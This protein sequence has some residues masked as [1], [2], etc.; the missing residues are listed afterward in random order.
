MTTMLALALFTGVASPATP[1][2]NEGALPHAQPQQVAARLEAVESAGFDRS[3]HRM[4]FLHWYAEPASNR[5]GQCIL[6]SVLL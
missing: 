2:W 5:T 4:P 3:A 1:L 6:K